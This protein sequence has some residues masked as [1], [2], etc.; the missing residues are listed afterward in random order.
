MM[1]YLFC[2]FI[3]F[4]LPGYGTL[5]AQASADTS[6][7]TDTV[8]ASD[9]VTATGNEEV[10]SNVDSLY[11]PV[12]D[13]GYLPFPTRVVPKRQVQTYL[14]NPDYAYANDPEYWAK[15][16]PE[17]PGTFSGLL[18]SRIFQWIIFGGIICLVLVGIYQLARENNFSWLT[19]KGSQYS[20]VEDVE[21]PDEEMDYD[22]A[23][24]KYQEEGNYRLAI[25]FMY[26]RLIRTVKEKSGIP[27]RDSS[28]N[29]EIAGALSQHPQ[30]GEFR[31]L[32]IAYEYVFYGGFIP[33]QELFVSL[34][35][36]FD[37]LQNIR[38]L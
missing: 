34:K 27:F 4:M 32:T 12:V 1:K 31:Y 16:A 28:T 19:R 2:L 15:R 10:Q 37:A 22:D 24:R 21:I 5:F 33:N 26:L 30:A 3:F 9:T 36:K 20:S 35:N 38:P 8:Q 17:K 23:I 6:I 25:R 14:D 7:A 18:N 29:A 13:S 11:N